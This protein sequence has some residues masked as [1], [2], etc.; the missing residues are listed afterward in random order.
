MT[1]YFYTA[2]DYQ[3]VYSAA[4]SRKGQRTGRKHATGSGAKLR[5]SLILAGL[6][7]EVVAVCML[8]SK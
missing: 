1:V 4:V 2:H 8:R 5:G 7:S 3:N 6:L